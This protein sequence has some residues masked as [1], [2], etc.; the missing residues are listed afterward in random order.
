MKNS[1]AV[2]NVAGYDK[3]EISVTKEVSLYGEDFIKIVANNDEFGRK[4][5]EIYP[6]YSVDE[7]DIRAEAKN[8]ILYLNWEPNKKLQP[9]KITVN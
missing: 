3:N 7:S 1:K 5:T 8:G 6:E 9:V 4:S 2:V